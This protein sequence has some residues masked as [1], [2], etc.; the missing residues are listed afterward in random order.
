LILAVI[1]FHFLSAGGVFFL[2]PAG[3]PVI[4]SAVPQNDGA[5]IQLLIIFVVFAT[6][7]FRAVGCPVLDRNDSSG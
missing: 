1:L 3:Y 6:V 7:R 4:A 5:D 2:S